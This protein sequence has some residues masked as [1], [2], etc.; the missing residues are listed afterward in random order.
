FTATICTGSAASYSCSYTE[1]LFDTNGM[2]YNLTVFA[3][4]FA[5][6]AAQSSSIFKFDANAPITPTGLAATASSSSQINLSWIAST[7]NV[8]VTGYKV[9]R[10]GSQVG[11]AT[12][13]SYQ[14]TGLS[15]STSYT[16]TVSAYDA[17]G[18]N[19]AQ[20]SS[21]SATTQAS[22]SG[23]SAPTISSSTHTNDS[24]STN[25]DPQF[26]WNSVSGAAYYSYEFNQASD[27]EPT[28]TNDTNSTS[29]NPDGT[30][31]D[32]IWH[33]HIK[34]CTAS[35]CSSTAR[36]KVKID[37]TG[38]AQPQDVSLTANSDGT[39]GISWSGVSDLPSGDNS[40]LK[41]YKIYRKLNDDT[42]D[43]SDSIGTT[44]TTSFTDDSSSLNNGVRYFYRIRAFDNAGNS[45]TLSGAKSVLVNKSGTSCSSQF[46]YNVQGFLKGSGVDIKVTATKAMASPSLKVRIVGVGFVNG[47]SI[48]YKG[49]YA[50]GTYNFLPQQD[51]KTAEVT[52][53]ATDPNGVLCNSSKTF[54]IDSMGPA[55][56]EIF[57]ASGAEVDF[58][59]KSVFS[60][61]ITD[62]QS[63]VAS[64]ALFYKNGAVFEKIGD[65]AKGTGENYSVE[66]L[67]AEVTDLGIKTGNLELKIEAKD[68]AGNISEKTF[69]INVTHVPSTEEVYSEKEYTF[70]END[71][72]ALLKNSG[73][74]EK[75]VSTAKDLIKNNQV[76]RTLRAIKESEAIY[77][78][79]IVLSFENKTQSTIGI[80]IAEVIPKE[81]AQTAAQIQSADNFTILMDDPVI[82]FNFPATAPGEIADV[83]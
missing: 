59:E 19:S 26:S 11:T 6:I 73:L 1:T 77:G 27:T 33:F 3:S 23:I 34:A 81:L 47:T 76:K 78:V 16:Y 9:F 67:P 55:I 41:E 18:N 21:A 71:L 14:D 57:P 29:F 45:G 4:N 25:N 38:P 53:T 80:K 61:T 68:N 36:F 13:I 2:D 12:T 64:A 44:T 75:L 83:T 66:V 70:N 46:S 65:A 52:L 40:G 62:A 10:N 74:E 30:Q 5:G 42:P 49:T 28:N 7:D 82:E 69:T 63:G 37:K 17:A 79:Y 48:D 39:V 22:G 60:A 58:S 20:S 50:Q 31:S 8:A 72:E 15:A 51:G 56:E 54:T 24:W 32:G 35:A 43:D